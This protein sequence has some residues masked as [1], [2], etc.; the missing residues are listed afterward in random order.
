MKVDKS[1]LAEI[2]NVSNRG[3][4]HIIEKEQLTEKL[5]NKG[6]SLI[7]KIKEGRKVF[8]IIEPIENQELIELYDNLCKEV[9]NT[10][11]KMSFGYCCYQTHFYFC[12]TEFHVTILP[13]YN[14]THQTRKQF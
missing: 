4:R 11:N 6:Y 10:S 2:L 5:N 9:Y 3:L 12:N 1:K 14:F 7:N 8:Y 13:C